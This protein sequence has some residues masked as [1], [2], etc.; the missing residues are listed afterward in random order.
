[1]KKIFLTL[2]LSLVTNSC[3]CTDN[4]YEEF[5]NSFALNYPHNQ[6]YP[7]AGRQIKPP[8]PSKQTTNGDC[9]TGCPAPDKGCKFNYCEKNTC[10]YM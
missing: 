4:K 10:Y 2:I 8:C 7:K 6:E 1:M 5:I 9:N 3:E